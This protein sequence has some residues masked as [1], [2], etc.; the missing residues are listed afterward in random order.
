MVAWPLIKEITGFLGALCAAVPWLRDFS[1]RTKLASWIGIRATGSL[2]ATRKEV[3]D[4]N[5]GWL[6]R[7][8]F[9]LNRLGIPTAAKL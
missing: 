4:Q 6:E 9:S 5:E 7:A 2:E 8:G 3:A 1:R